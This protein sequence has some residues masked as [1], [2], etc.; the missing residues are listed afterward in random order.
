MGRA[1]HSGSNWRTALSR[2][3][4]KNTEGTRTLPSFV[5][6]RPSLNPHKNN[7]FEVSVAVSVSS[8]YSVINRT[9]RRT[10]TVCF[11]G[12]R[13]KEEPRQVEEHGSREQER[14]DPVQHPSVPLDQRS[15]VFHP[16]IP[17]DRRHHQSARETHQRDR[18]RHERGL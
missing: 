1:H 13:Y 15:V 9:P 12:L 14:V 11:Q 3:T 8:A 4:L 2:N 6:W 10:L 5:S 17:L 16:A 18:E 7:E